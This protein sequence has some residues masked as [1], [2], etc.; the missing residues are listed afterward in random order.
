MHLITNASGFATSSAAALTV[1]ATGGQSRLINV[2]TRGLV[3][4]GGALTPG[5]VMRG[6]GSKQLVIRAVAPTLGQF[7]V[8]GVLNDPK[9]EIIPQGAAT[10]LLS[11]DNWDDS[12]SLSA[13]FAAV[14][15]FALVPNTFVRGKRIRH[16]PAAHRPLSP[17]F[18]GQGYWRRK[19]L[20]LLR[21]AAGTG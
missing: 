17:E 1:A 15:A 19:Y 21:W 13:A 5:F 12:P 16:V 6:S 11:N 4:A 7:G 20:E 18:R 8:I 2:A 9:L 14:G 3:Q 10:P